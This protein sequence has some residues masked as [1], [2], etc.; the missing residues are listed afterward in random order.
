M[1]QPQVVVHEF[2]E[3][4]ALNYKNYK[5]ERLDQTINYGN[6]PVQVAID[7]GRNRGQL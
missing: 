6:S 7:H 2:Q 3:I 5:R 1:S 4:Y